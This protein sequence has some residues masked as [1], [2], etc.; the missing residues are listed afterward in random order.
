MSE[1]IIIALIGFAGA[2]LAAIISVYLKRP[3]QS[4]PPTKAKTASAESGSAAK[5]P[6]MGQSENKPSLAKPNQP[7]STSEIM[8]SIRPPTIW[9][10]QPNNMWEV[11]W[12]FNFEN[13]ANREV[14]L[15][16]DAS[17]FE[18]RDSFGQIRSTQ[19]NF[20]CVSQD[21]VLKPGGVFAPA[22]G[23]RIFL[24]NDG[25]IDELTLIVRNVE[26][27]AEKSWKSR[28]PFPHGQMPR[29]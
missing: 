17:N 23:C 3:D 8:V 11:Q 19:G 20:G 15:R 4:Q 16:Y 18:V 5:E 6:K 27:I 13:R 25:K 29:N 1:G 21:I 22:D 24:A 2:I 12:F 10:P 7:Q 26:G 9:A 28:P 14:R